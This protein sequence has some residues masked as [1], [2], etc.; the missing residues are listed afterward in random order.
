MNSANQETIILT[1]DAS[2]YTIA[3]GGTYAI[4]IGQIV[5]S[6][7]IC[8]PDIMAQENE[9]LSILR[10]VTQAAVQ[11]NR[12]TLDSPAGS[13]VFYLIEPK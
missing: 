7:L 8:P 4:T 2:Q 10:Q 12:I 13:M 9:Y 11:Q 3:P 6:L 1:T 5:T